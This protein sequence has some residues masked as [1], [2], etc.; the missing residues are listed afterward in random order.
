MGGARPQTVEIIK[1]LGERCPEVVVTNQTQRANY[2]VTLDHEGG[3]G[4]LRVKNKIVVFDRSGDSI[5]SDST[6]T[7]GDAVQRACFAIR[8]AGADSNASLRRGLTPEYFAALNKLPKRFA[9]SDV[10]QA[11]GSGHADDFINRAIEAGFVEK[12]G[13]VHYRIK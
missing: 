1:T 2:I 5:F 13:L 9:R 12:D 10:D 11:V 7:L 6:Q 4:W 8:K 3:K